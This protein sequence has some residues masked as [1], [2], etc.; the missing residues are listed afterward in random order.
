MTRC[1]FLYVRALSLVGSLECPET[2]LSVIPISPFGLAFRTEKEANP[3]LTMLSNAI[4]SAHP[5]R[6]SS[7][8]C[9]VLE[10]SSEYAGPLQ[11]KLLLRPGQLKQ[12]IDAL[13]ENKRPTLAKRIDP[14]KLYI[15]EDDSDEKALQ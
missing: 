6:L 9:A 12:A 7:L 5:R 14:W 13:P 1:F 10:T 15:G 2:H 8:L 11:E 4:H 3:E